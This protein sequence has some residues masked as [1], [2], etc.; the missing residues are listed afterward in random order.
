MQHHTVRMGTTGRTALHVS[1][2]QP[3]EK[4]THC[5][6]A[7]NSDRAQNSGGKFMFTDQLSKCGSPFWQPV[8]AKEH[9]FYTD[10]SAVPTLSV[11]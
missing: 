8:Q 5:R 2:A 10:V 7:P 1:D 4:K 6:K 3:G 9:M 11:G